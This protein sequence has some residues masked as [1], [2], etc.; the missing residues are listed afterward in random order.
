LKIVL[1]KQTV[2]GRWIKQNGTRALQVEEVGQ[3]SKWIT[4]RAL[5]AIKHAHRVVL[6]V[7][8]AKLSE[9]GA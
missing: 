4:I 2:E 5:R 7:E 3:P 1:D 8:R 9:R 6:Q